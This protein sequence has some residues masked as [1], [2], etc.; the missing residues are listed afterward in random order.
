MAYVSQLGGRNV[1]SPFSISSLPAGELHIR[2]SDAARDALGEALGDQVFFERDEVAVAARA[3]ARVGEVLGSFGVETLM[4]IGAGELGE[5]LTV[6][7]NLPFEQVEW[8]P[9]PGMP[10]RSA[11]RTCLSEM[12]LI[13]MG[14]HMGELYGVA[15]EGRRLVND[16]IP[17][18]T[19]LDRHTG[20]GSRKLLGLH[21]EN[22]APRYLSAG[23][24][25]SPK[26]L[27]LTGV[28]EQTVGGPA[29]PVAI[30]ARA[31]ARLSDA[32]RTVL[33]NA[34]AIL[35][36]PQR[37]RDH[38]EIQDIGPV[39]VILGPAGREQVVAAFYGDLTRPAFEAA[40]GPLERLEAELN[41]VAIPL[42]IVP[43]RMVH[44]ANGR[45]LHGRTDF[46]AEFDAEGRARRWIQRVF[47][48]GRVEQFRADGDLHERVY[49]LNPAAMAF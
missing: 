43:G 40:A 10:A 21:Y 49:A 32:D 24:D 17:S 47:L 1:V 4:R 5:G 12:L 38:A 28:S 22:A 11:K 16:L 8:S 9:F 41:A 31:V 35:K 46:E 39:P 26:A 14:P 25:F 30:A 34:C 48:G 44:L 13:G 27:M 36:A 15:S 18:M 37:W 6:F 45:V 7:D 33:R 2:F 20:N 29:T 42:Q 3:S 23:R 19:D